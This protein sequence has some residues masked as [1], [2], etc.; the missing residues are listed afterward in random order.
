MRK[1]ILIFALIGLAV[2]EAQSAGAGE[3]DSDRG[4][5]YVR[6]PRGTTTEIFILRGTEPKD[7]TGIKVTDPEPAA[8]DEAPKTKKVRRGKRTYTVPVE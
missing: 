6:D 5:N 8:K 3:N 7:Q 4:R 1:H 2:G